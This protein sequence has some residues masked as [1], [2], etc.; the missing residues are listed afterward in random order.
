MASLKFL[1]LLY[2]NQH[3]HRLQLLWFVLTEQRPAV[4]GSLVEVGSRILSCLSENPPSPPIAQL[5]LPASS[6]PGFP[7]SCWMVQR[8]P[9]TPSLV[10][11]PCLSLP[12]HLG[13]TEP[14]AGCGGMWGSVSG[15][16]LGEE[17]R[18]CILF[19]RISLLWSRR[20]HR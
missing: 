18:F 7:G 9:L 14:A 19:P 20:L 8:G 4:L 2:L 15:V 16:L 5:A 17:A 3:R 10:S 12:Y 1:L 11:S 13:A 6:Q